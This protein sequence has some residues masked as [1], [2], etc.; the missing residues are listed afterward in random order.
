M[1]SLQ[2][3]TNSRGKIICGLFEKTYGLGFW[4]KCRKGTGNEVQD[5]VKIS[6]YKICFYAQL[7]GTPTISL[8]WFGFVA[9]SEIP[10]RDVYAGFPQTS[11]YLPVQKA[12]TDFPRLEGISALAEILFLRVVQCSPEQLYATAIVCNCILGW[13]SPWASCTTNG[14]GMCYRRGLRAA[15]ARSGDLSE[16]STR[17]G[18][19]NVLWFSLPIKHSFSSNSS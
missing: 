19:E 16:A 1:V 9:T 5:N 18:C 7:Q 13:A 3:Q 12:A 8:S 11:G 4:L 15:R 17:K 14:K 10:G 6:P 2:W